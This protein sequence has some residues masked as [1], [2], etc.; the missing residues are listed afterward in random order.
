MRIA[1][2]LAV[3]VLATA[4]QD[5]PD[6]GTRRTES[7]G[8]PEAALVKAVDVDSRSTDD[9]REIASA[10]DASRLGRLHQ[11][12]R[13]ARAEADEQGFSA[14][15]EALGPLVDPNAAL[16]GR[17]QPPPGRYRCRLLMLGSQRSQQPPFVEGA[18]GSCTVE[19]SPGGTLSLTSSI[20][21][22][23]ARGLLYPD[24]ERRLVFI[25][26]RSG[27][28]EDPPGFSYGSDPARDRV[29]VL[30]RIGPDRWRLAAPWPHQ[31]AKLELL[32]LTR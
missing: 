19:L 4:C 29:G 15:V 8:P 13:L 22:P 28:R 25:G 31:G 9:W 16:A 2:A 23:G 14:A 26:V 17:L 3:L 5:R 24:G 12:W 6:H 18:W 32:E 11:A 30:E 27:E 20:A 21:P 1:P 10:E 7:S